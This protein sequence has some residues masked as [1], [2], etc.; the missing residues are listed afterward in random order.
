MQVTTNT[1]ASFNV[2]VAEAAA[3]R[4]FVVNK[5]GTVGSIAY[6]IE[7]GSKD[8]R[9]E[10]AGD[11]RN[12]WAANG[13]YRPLFNDFLAAGLVPKAA[14]PYITSLVPAVGPISKD[15]FIMFCR[16]IDAAFAVKEAEGK[17]TKGVKAV[18]LAIVRKFAS[19]ALKAEL[20]IEA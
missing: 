6:L 11:I 12:T 10:V 8:A 14:L 18:Q 4:G 19:Q 7:A 15:T 17:V 16:S 3:S 20:T 1:T 9:A 13:Q 5:R 2:V